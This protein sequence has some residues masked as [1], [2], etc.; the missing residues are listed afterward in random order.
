MPSSFRRSDFLVE[1]YRPVQMQPDRKYQSGARVY[2]RVHRRPF[3]MEA[4][5]PSMVALFHVREAVIPSEAL[6]AVAEFAGGYDR[7][8]V[9]IL[10]GNGGT[11][12]DLP[13][14]E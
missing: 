7:G 3:A 6:A 10:V 1:I 13:P 8:N 11:L 14:L 2:A 4:F 5:H 12:A 9:R